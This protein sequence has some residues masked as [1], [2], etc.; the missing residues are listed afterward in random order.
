MPSEGVI[1]E[2]DGVGNQRPVVHNSN[3]TLCY[4]RQSPPADAKGLTIGAGGVSSRRTEVPR[5]RLILSVNYAAS[6]D[7]RS[8]DEASKLTSSPTT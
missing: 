3:A 1:C 8:Y 4:I 2:S 5:A 6:E 7:T